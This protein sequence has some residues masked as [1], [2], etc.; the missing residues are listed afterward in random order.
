MGNEG[1]GGDPLEHWQGAAGKPVSPEVCSAQQSCAVAASCKPP[2]R[3]CARD[4]R[5]NTRKEESE[6]RTDPS[7]GHEGRKTEESAFGDNL[8]YHHPPGVRFSL[9]E[10]IGVSC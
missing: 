10:F 2:A 5:G 7:N 6:R 9:S 3:R 8:R 4:L 1:V